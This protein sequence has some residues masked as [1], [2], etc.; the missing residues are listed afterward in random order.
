[1]RAQARDLDVEIVPIRLGEPLDLAD[2]DMLLLG[3]GSDREQAVVARGLPQYQS[4]MRQAVEAGMPIL[5][6]CGGYQLLGDYYELPSGELVKGL[7]L[8]EMYTKAGFSSRLIGNVAIEWTSLEQRSR[9][10]IVGFENHGGRTYHQYPALGKVLVGHGN[11]GEDRY[12][13]LHYRG[14]IGT[15]VHGPLL[16]KNPHLADHLLTEARAFRGIH[17]PLAVLD[18]TLEWRAHDQV[19][20][21]LGVSVEAGV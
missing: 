17:E 3:G 12:E 5:A 21:T 14:I 6:V 11:N 2:L 16:P 4:D 10:T 20:Q 19:L 9:K 18:D 1:M 15:Y 13:G 8:V 7:R